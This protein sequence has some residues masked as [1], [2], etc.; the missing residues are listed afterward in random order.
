MVYLANDENRVCPIMWKSKSILRVVRNTLSAECS[1]M[2]DA[3]DS[4]CFLSYVLSEIFYYDQIEKVT[5]PILAYTDN[6]SLY[7]NVHSTLMV[8]EHRLR[9]GIAI[10]KHM[11]SENDI[12]SFVWAPS[13]EQLA[14]C[15]SKNV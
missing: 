7:R 14:D 2:V 11:I 1:T 10:I 6:K 3:L 4:S 15:F 9:L 5:I 12:Q 13:N 8:A